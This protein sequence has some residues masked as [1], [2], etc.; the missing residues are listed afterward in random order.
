[1]TIQVEQQD[2]AHFL[3]GL[4][5]R[6]PIE[7][8]ISAVFIGTDTVWKL[9][10]AVHMPFLDFTTL[11]ARAH[12]LRRELEINKPGAPGLYRDVI[13]ITRNGNGALS[14]GDDDPVDFVLRMARVPEKDFLES[15]VSAHGMTTELLDALADT[16]AAYHAGLPPRYDLDTAAAMLRITGGNVRSAVA[17]G[18]ARSVVASWRQQMEAAI[19]AL[20][21]ILSARV[22]AGYVRRCHGDLHLGNIC[23]WGG[24]P[25]LFDALEFDE[26][27][28]TID[29]SY[30]LAFL[31]MDLDQRVGRAA[32]NRVMNRYV[33]R[34][35]DVV[36]AA[37]LPIFL[38]QRAMIRAHVLPAM[39][40][41]GS[42]YL[43]AAQSYLA[44]GEPVILAIGGLQGTGKSTLARTLAPGLGL[45]PGALIVRSDEIRK[46]LHSQPPEARLPPQAY[47]PSANAATNTAV[48]EQAGMGAQAGRSVIVDATFLDG[49]IRHQLAAAVAQTG[50]RFVGVWLQAPLPVLEARIAARLGDASDATVAVLRRSARND[51]GAGD[52][53]AVDAT[54]ATQA[55]AVVHGALSGAGR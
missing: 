3:S 26:A 2:V 12:F 25:V 14:F 43:M 10:K 35:G 41:D 9:K 40:Q 34:T 51:P 38:S 1:M 29:V 18:L 36:V 30:D 5:G 17:A 13:G 23:L 55:A 45:A 49:T 7:T 44:P 16:V 19:E 50:A 6:P 24:K 8:H 21:P 54:D 27:L 53:L 39:G 20:R 48:V 52:W 4:A 47:T 42:A 31:L 37:A 15:I 33:A 11:Q 22:Q 32:A 46:R 28:A